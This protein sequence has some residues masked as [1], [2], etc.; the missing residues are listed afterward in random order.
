MWAAAF[1]EGTRAV[2][3]WN[4]GSKILFVDEKGNG[5]FAE[6]IRNDPGEI[7]SFRHLGWTGNWKELPADMEFNIGG[8]IMKWSG[9]DENYILT[10][11][12]DLTTLTVEMTGDYGDWENHLTSAYPKAL[13]YVKEL[14]EK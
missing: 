13:Q 3:D 14:S 4:T 1:H 2:S 10:A 11:E 7:M 8:K 12:D 6:I 9:G 5:A